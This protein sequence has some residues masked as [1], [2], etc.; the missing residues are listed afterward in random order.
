MLLSNPIY[1]GDEQPIFS[2]AHGN[3]IGLGSGAAPSVTTI[4][5]GRA[6]F[7]SMKT[8]TGYFL[9]VG[10]AIILT[11]PAQETAAQQMVGRIT[12]TLTA[13]LNPF[14]EALTHI[15]DA[16]IQDTS[17]YLLA[18]QN[19]LPAFMWGHLMGASG[20]RIRTFAPFGVQGIVRGA[21]PVAV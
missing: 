20:P 2:S 17:W 3:V 1:T 4:G 16:N 10:P 6:A 21:K 18:D 19:I 9:N 5:T 14:Q 7:R 15:S 13:S 12:P 11:G 8:P